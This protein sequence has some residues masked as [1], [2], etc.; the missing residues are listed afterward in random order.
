VSDPH[1]RQMFT[2]S[3]ERSGTYGSW[4][5]LLHCRCWLILVGVLLAFPV[6]AAE[7]QRLADVRGVWQA[8]FNHDASRLIVRTRQGDIG[9]WDAKKGTR[10]NGDPG[11]TKPS[12]AYI[13]SPD[14]R[15]FLVGFKDGKA[16]VFDASS[17]SAVSPVLDLALREDAHPQTVFSPDG[18]TLIFFGEK[19]SSVLEVKTGKRIATIPIVFELEENSDSTTAAIFVEGGAKCFVM[20]PKGTVTAYQ[21]KTWTPV[22]KPMSHPA[23]EMAYDFGFEASSDGKWVVTFDG[24]GENGPKGQLQAWDAVA[25]KPLGEPLS[26][27]NG[28]SGQ[29]LTGQSRLLVQSGRGD[30]TVRD[31]P[32][33]TTAY[34]IKQ[35]DDIDGP[36]IQVFPNGKLL[37][38][39]GPDNKTD[40]I[41]TVS[42]R[43]LKTHTLPVSVAGAL[44]S[45]DSSTCY[46][47]VDNSTFLTQGHW[48]YYLQRLSIPDWEVTG[49]IRIVDFLARKSLS[50]DGRWLV[51]VQGDS[52]HERVAVFDTSTL[53]PIEWPAR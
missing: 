42:G 33:M 38:A 21:T 47:E 46:L 30:A 19:E 49:S 10:I 25:S 20:D 14:A 29:F 28:M 2:D 22:G 9:L 5:I 13:L 50:A 51:A 6:N 26:A 40:L 15:R 8:E 36:R 53:K 31:L 17:G 18:A 3:M 34:V 35:H 39:W 24:P 41:D 16:R 48:D 45:P 7:S 37:A 12:A 52:D 44:I 43:I 32:S 11:L 27:V 1:S 4:R 23:A